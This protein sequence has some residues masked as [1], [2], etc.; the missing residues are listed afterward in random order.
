[1]TRSGR[2]SEGMVHPSL[3]TKRIGN[4]LIFVKTTS[5]LLHLEELQRQYIINKIVYALCTPFISSLY[6]NLTFAL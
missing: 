2:K 5:L 3:P 6:R 1:M 4:T